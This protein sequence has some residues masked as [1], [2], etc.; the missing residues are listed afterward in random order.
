MVFQFGK[1][2]PEIYFKRKEINVSI[3]VEKAQFIQN[4]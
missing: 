1:T 2:C 3:C 4:I